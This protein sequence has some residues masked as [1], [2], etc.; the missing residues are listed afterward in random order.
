MSTMTLAGAS[1]FDDVFSDVDSFLSPVRATIARM[2]ARPIG[3]QADAHPEMAI[4]RAGRGDQAAFAEF[5]DEVSGVVYGTTLRVLRNPAIAE[6]VTQDVFLEL[7]KL[8]PRYD[9]SKGS[10][11]A[12]AA[13]IAHRRAVDR[14]RSEE[15]ARARDEV[16]ARESAVDYDVV[17]D[18]VTTEADRSAVQAALMQLSE[19]QREAVSLAFYGGHTYREVAA[20][21]DV[22]EG[23]IKTRIRDG[24]SKLRVVM[25][26]AT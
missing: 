6:E 8:A 16:D 20:I 10:P 9:R 14:V 11:K 24:L 2:T 3:S 25:G 18:A 22:P 19:A 7:W 15:S 26:P 21:L 17:V 13:T 23:T 4:E 12:W 1:P 5:Y